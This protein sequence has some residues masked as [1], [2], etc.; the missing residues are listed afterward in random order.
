MT[1]FPT[2]AIWPDDVDNRKCRL[3]KKSMRRRYRVSL[4]SD[5]F[6]DE[7]RPGAGSNS[8]TGGGILILEV[9]P[10]P[11]KRRPMDAL[12]SGRRSDRPKRMRPTPWSWRWLRRR[13]DCIRPTWHIGLVCYPIT[14]RATSSWSRRHARQTR[15]A[16]NPRR[17]Y[18]TNSG[19]SSKRQTSRDRLSRQYECQIDCSLGLLFTT[20]TRQSASRGPS[21][22]QT[23]VLKAPLNGCE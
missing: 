13:R 7:L 6:S 9:R 16:T 5:A 22:D 1:G 2:G 3:A 21:L 11:F 17:P 15:H 8:T 20:R 14:S 10:C 23:D 12:E 18:Q 4:R 19:Q